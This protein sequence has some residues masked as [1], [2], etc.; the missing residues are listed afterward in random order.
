M[1]LIIDG[2]NLLN[3]TTLEVPT[4]QG[5][6]LHQLRTALLDFLA[7]RLESKE[8]SVTTVV[9]DARRAPPGL[10]R[11]QDYRQITVRFA[12]RDREADD[13]IEELIRAD[14]APRRLTVVS[15]DHRVQRAARRRRARAFDSDVWFRQF[16]QRPLR[17]PEEPDMPDPESPQFEEDPELQRWLEQFGDRDQAAP[18][19]KPS[20]PPRPPAAND[21]D[22]PFPPGYAEDLLD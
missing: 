4:R 5:A 12:P 10:A 14:S 1:A 17:E 3:V 2:Y 22:H 15:S 13:V 11:V 19:R 7:Q 20:P 16:C 9:F 6:S 8:R 21:H 18:R